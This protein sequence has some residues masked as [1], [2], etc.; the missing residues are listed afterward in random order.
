[1]SRVAFV[2]GAASG[3]GQA[4]ARE[5]ARRGYRVVVADA[6]GPGAEATATGL[7]DALALE[8]DV[9]DEPAVEH[10]FVAATEWGG[11]IDLLVNCAG[12]VVA[13]TLAETTLEEW[14]RVFAVN[15]RGTFLC[16]R[17]ALRGMIEHGG[18]VIVNVA[19][20]AA[21]VGIPDRAAYCASKGA[22][23]AMTK[24]IAVDHVH[25]GIR[26]N[27]VC[28]GSTMTP[29]VERLMAESDDAEATLEMIRARQ[30][31]GRLGKPEEI[32]AAIAY[33]ASDEAAFA[34]GSEL[35]IDGGLSAR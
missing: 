25:Q 3:I 22:I 10:A 32:A 19:S 8:V 17:A 23:V 11:G 5:L 1:V 9:S 24:A 20:V 6:N 12:A 21:F 13:K 29:W 34:T 35:V 28:P 27:S 30:P 4:T 14:E 31:M 26:A 15:V 33:L 18:G 7:P 16:S 2:T